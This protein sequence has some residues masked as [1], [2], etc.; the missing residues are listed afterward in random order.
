MLRGPLFE[1]TFA[2]TLGRKSGSGKSQ[3]FRDADTV[4]EFLTGSAILA[5]FDMP[6]VPLFIAVSFLLHP[7]FGWLAIGAGIITFVIAVANEYWTKAS[8]NRA[9]QASMSAHADVSA[10][11]RNAEVMRA[12]GMASG[13]QGALGQTAR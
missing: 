12:M 4:R 13:T 1:A 10:T 9:T 3:P 6:W 5:F 8:L 11:L 7:I 2:A